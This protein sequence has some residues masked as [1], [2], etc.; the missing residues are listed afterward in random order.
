MTIYNIHHTK[1]SKPTINVDETNIDTTATDLKFFGRRRLQYGQDMNQNIMFLLEHFACPEDASNP[2]NPN[3]TLAVNPTNS[4][5][6]FTP[7]INPTDGQLWYNSTQ[8]RLFSWDNSLRKWISVGMQDDIAANWGIIYNDEQIPHPVSSKTGYV[9]PYSECSWIVSPYQFPQQ[10]DYMLVDTDANA[11]VSS[12]YSLTGDP[13]ILKGFAT[14]LIVGIKGNINLGNLSPIPSTTPTPAVTVTPSHT[15]QPTPAVTPS[16]TPVATPTYSGPLVA[17]FGPRFPVDGP[18]F[19]GPGTAQ[20]YYAG[21]YHRIRYPGISD[22]KY[23]ILYS[24]TAPLALQT[25]PPAPHNP[26]DNVSGAYYIYVLNNPAA[27]TK[28]TFLALSALYKSIIFVSGKST[29]AGTAM[30][31]GTDGA[32]FKIGAVTNLGGGIIQIQLAVNPL[33][34]PDITLYN[35]PPIQTSPIDLLRFNYDYVY[36]TGAY[37]NTHTSDVSG[38]TANPS[39]SGVAGN[40]PNARFYLCPPTSLEGSFDLYIQ[41]GAPPYTITDIRYFG[42]SGTGVFSSFASNKIPSLTKTGFVASGQQTLP[43]PVSF[44]DLNGASAIKPLFVGPINFPSANSNIQQIANGYVV[45]NYATADLNYGTDFASKY[46]TACVPEWL[47]YL[48]GSGEGGACA[49]L[50]G[51]TT[52]YCFDSFCVF[53]KDSTGTTVTAAVNHGGDFQT[54]DGDFMNQTFAF[55]AT[56][57]SGPASGSVLTAGTYTYGLNVNLGLLPTS[58]RPLVSPAKLQYVLSLLDSG[59]GN[60]SLPTASGQ[61]Q[62]SSVTGTTTTALMSRPVTGNCPSG[63]ITPANALIHIGCDI[64]NADPDLQ[65]PSGGYIGSYTYG[66]LA[67]GAYQQITINKVWR[68]DGTPGVQDISAHPITVRLS[69]LSSPLGT[70]NNVN[71]Y[72]WSNLLPDRTG[73]H[74]GSFTSPRVPYNMKIDV[75]IPTGL[76]FSGTLIIPYGAFAYDNP[77]GGCAFGTAGGPNGNILLNFA[78]T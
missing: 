23:K 74:T 39:C 52:T 34:N 30:V 77:S 47:W 9:F 60:A 65:C 61:F 16:N 62:Y 33:G 44:T 55:G 63:S 20:P 64:S 42:P 71:T 18:F 53:V 5:V 68:N 66:P 43:A 22:T 67:P 14:Y 4:N 58:L 24:S 73:Q 49:N 25:S 26:W 27:G 72:N 69:V 17:Y 12:L 37:Y 31:E 40:D 48:N 35:H 41:G 76:S 59:Q 10:I 75:T 3:T 46:G 7:L 32:F 70:L 36:A 11:V 45:R 21:D 13:T 78:N 56:Q 8:Q 50:T 2:G 54:I 38:E 19:A 29:E 57:I 51:N 6:D 1:N 28:G 15:P